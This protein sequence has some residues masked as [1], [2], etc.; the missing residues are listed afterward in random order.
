MG[1]LDHDGG[2]ELLGRLDEVLKVGGRKVNP[3]EVELVLYR[4]PAV[5]EAAVVA[6]PDPSRI[7][8]N[9]LHAF[10]VPRQDATLRLARPGSTLPSPARILQGPSPDPPSHVAAQVAGREAV[11]IRIA[12][13]PVRHTS[14]G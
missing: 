12:E 6:Q 9:V 5:Q 14:L 3:A 13:Q 4:H 11:A 10:V 2:V 1:R 7:L 8:E